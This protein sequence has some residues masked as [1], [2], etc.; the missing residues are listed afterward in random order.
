MLPP[1]WRPT[2]RPFE[3]KAVGGELFWENKHRGGERAT[4]RAEGRRI[5]SRRRRPF[6]ALFS[7]LHFPDLLAFKEEEERG[8]R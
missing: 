3:L 8:T 4:Q 7:L 1:Q 5:M 2:G 6:A